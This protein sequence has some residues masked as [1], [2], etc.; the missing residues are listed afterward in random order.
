MGRIAPLAVLIVLLASLAALPQD[1]G[2]K[3]DKILN[4]IE[5]NKGATIH[6]DIVSLEALGRSAMD[7][8][9]APPASRCLSGT[10]GP[11]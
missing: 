3:V 11:A 5:D 7:D 9:R 4:R 10:Q 2:E 6:K 8:V 1:V